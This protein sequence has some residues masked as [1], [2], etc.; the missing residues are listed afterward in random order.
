MVWKGGDQVPGQ[1]FPEA[2]DR[3]FGDALQKMAWV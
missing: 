3:M 1:Q 2:V